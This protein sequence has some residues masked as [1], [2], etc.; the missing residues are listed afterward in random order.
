M[1]RRALTLEQEALELEQATT[2][3][4]AGVLP[5]VPCPRGCG[6]EVVLARHAGRELVLDPALKVWVW[7]GQRDDASPRILSQ[8]SNW[9]AE[10][11]CPSEDVNDV[12]G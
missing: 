5:K 2:C 1:N 7:L 4:G 3:L 6:R 11:R 9:L 12:R 10:H 8:P